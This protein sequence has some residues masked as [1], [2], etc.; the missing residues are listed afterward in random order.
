ML[1]CI[2]SSISCPTLVCL[3]R[4][5]A[6]QPMLSLNELSE[7]LPLLARLLW[8]LLPQFLMVQKQSLKTAT[9]WI[10]SPSANPVS[11]LHLSGSRSSSSS[12][13][14]DRNTDLEAATIPGSRLRNGFSARSGRASRLSDLLSSP[15]PP[16]ATQRMLAPRSPGIPLSQSESPG[17]PSAGPGGCCAHVGPRH[18]VPASG[19]AD[20]WAHKPRVAV[21][22]R[23]GGGGGGGAACRLLR[24]DGRHGQRPAGAQALPQ[25]S[26]P[27]QGAAGDQRSS[28]AT[29][30][31]ATAWAVLNLFLELL[32]SGFPE[33]VK[34]V[35]VGP[36]DGLQN[37]KAILPTDVK[38]ELIDQLSQTGLSV[39][40]VTSFVSSKWVPQMADHTE[41]MK[42]IKRYPGVCYPVLTPNLHGFHSAIAAG[43]TEVSVFGAASETFSKININC[44]IE[45]S[46]D[47]FEAV[48][49]SARNMDIP[50]R[51]YVSCALGCPYEGTIPPAKV[52]EVSKRLYSMGCYEVSLGDT[53]G[54]GTPGSMKRTLE[55]VMMEVP[56]SAVAVHCHDTYGQALANILTALQMGVHV[57]D[58]SV[59]GLGGCPYAKGATGN[60]ATEDVIYM[61][62]G[63][64]INTGVDLYKVM[65]AGNFIC[66]ALNKKTNSKVAQASFSN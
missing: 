1:Y 45:E 62:N 21:T 55:S 32:T 4:Y 18:W 50:V 65:E 40:E 6:Q 59:S 2:S 54:V 41:V 58:S 33:F 30:C 31:S 10:R 25:L 48:V 56:L 38:I 42:G 44:T 11:I 51:G 53:I 63:M 5:Y 7:I 17:I 15:P 47:R 27:P 20:G 52:A 66:R 8:D 14:E 29:D 64:G 46:L 24:G 23:T 35:E 22:L 60:V 19:L 13:A 34:I 43:A 9:C 57:V 49:K 39:I 12:R 37:E 61:L 3:L 26:P 16:P 28:P 36:R